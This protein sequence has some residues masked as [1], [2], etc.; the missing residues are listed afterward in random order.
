VNA[1]DAAR[2]L[3]VGLAVAILLGGCAAGAS[4]TP[5]PATPTPIVTPAAAA[6][7]A[8]SPARTSPGW[9]MVTISDSAL[10]KGRWQDDVVAADAYAKWIEQDLGVRVT[11]HPFFYGG[12][13][14]G[15]VLQQ[16]RSDP[17]LRAALQSADVILL[18]V[19]SGEG[20][21]LCPWD[22]AGYRPAPGTPAEYRACGKQLAASYAANAAAIVDEIVAVRSPADALIRAIDRW[23]VFYPTYQAMGLGTVT[24][25]VSVALN[26]GLTRAA[27]AHGIPV[28]QAHATFMGPD[29][30]TDPVAAGDVQ[31]DE[32]HLTDQGITTLASLL[33]GL[34]YEKASA[35][36]A[37]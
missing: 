19:P 34:G 20:K 31:R 26:A 9:T 27:A 10:G 30:T 15:F 5:A 16:I 1:S 29:G 14:S 17:S 24:H 8:A 6:T 35:T 36:P 28:A 18:T 13:T 2:R 11:V 37:P 4:P 21:D 12:S 25:D 22:A 7:A 3:P 32:L 23:D 33:R